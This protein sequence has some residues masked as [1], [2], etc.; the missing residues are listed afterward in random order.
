MTMQTM[1][2]RAARVASAIK[3]SGFTHA[4]IAKALGLTPGAVSQWATQRTIPSA[5]KLSAL[6]EFLRVSEWWLRTGEQPPKLDLFGDI[7][8]PETAEKFDSLARLPIGYT[9]YEKRIRR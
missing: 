6:A 8:P 1:Q 9:L 7:E 5:E 2:D 4:Q 3:N